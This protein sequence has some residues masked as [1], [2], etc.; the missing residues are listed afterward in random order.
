M[1]GIIAD[2]TENEGIK[3]LGAIS[4]VTLRTIEEN[5][6][7]LSMHQHHK[8]NINMGLDDTRAPFFKEGVQ[9]Y[10]DNGYTVSTRNSGGRSVANDLG[11]LNFSLILQNDLSASENYMMFYNFVKDALSP[12]GL[13]IDVGLVEGAYC[14]GK[15]DVSI[16]GKKIMGTAQRRIGKRVLVGGYLSVNGDQNRVAKK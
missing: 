12:L 1:R 5:T 9:H 14:P 8:K 7:V 3:K 2:F 4:D 6:I 15:F 10:I 16:D 13:Q 11:V